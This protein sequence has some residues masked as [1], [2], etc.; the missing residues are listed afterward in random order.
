MLYKEY[1][2]NKGNDLYNL[3]VEINKGYINFILLDYNN[4]FNSIYKN[5]I[6]I[7]EF[8]NNLQVN[9]NFILKPNLLLKQFDEIFNNHQII[10]SEK[11]DN[12]INITINNINSFK[13]KLTKEYLNIE[14]K[15]NLLFNEIRFIQYNK[16]M[17]I[18]NIKY[19]N[20]NIN[21]KEDDI[22]NQINEKDLIINKLDNKIDN[23]DK[24]TQNEIKNLG[25]KIEQIIINQNKII[26]DV[27]KKL[28]DFKFKFGKNI[29]N[30]INNL[31]DKTENIVKDFSLKKNDLQMNKNI[32]YL[33]EYFN[34]Y[35]NLN[36]Q[37]KYSSIQLIFQ[38]KEFNSLS[39]NEFENKIYKELDIKQL[40]MLKEIFNDVIVRFR[41]PLNC[42]DYRGNKIQGWS[43]NQKRGKIYYDPPLG[44]IG[45][46]L[47]V[48]DKYENNTW[49]GNNNSNGEWCIAYHGVGC[50]QASD[51]IKNIIKCICC[52]SFKAGSHQIYADCFDILNPENKIGYGVYFSPFI[53]CA[54]MYAGTCCINNNNY[55][56]VLMVRIN[57]KSIRQCEDGRHYYI[58]NGT[59]DEV[60]P[61]RI[62]FKRIE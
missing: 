33:N 14:D 37:D 49:I 35:K 25:A 4:S 31:K 40:K 59:T 23:I 51:H 5:K 1:S 28:N 57:P 20:L 9:N 13:I 45:I 39:N 36:S 34:I 2:I 52:S 12:N 58:V 41:L 17:D 18:D 30:E 6:K 21:K 61:Y 27:M 44:W 10:I 53:N 24:K 29:Y 7:I 8:I 16:K 3:G 60:R 38:S 19:I 32:E 56:I 43:I 11:T 22:K 48:I 46:G 15:I 42:L 26:E 54:E 55:K 50:Y 62:L 47:K